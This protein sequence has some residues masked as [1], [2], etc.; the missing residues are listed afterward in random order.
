M[1]RFNPIRSG[2]FETANDL[3]VGALKSPPPP[4]TTTSKTIVSI[5]TISYM[6][7]LLG[8]LGNS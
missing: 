1:N 4:P 8:V 3:G 5:V 6:C 7:I 2:I